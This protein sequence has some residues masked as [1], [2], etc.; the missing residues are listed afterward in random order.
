MPQDCR[1]IKRHRRHTG[2]VGAAL[3][4]AVMWHAASKQFTGGLLDLVV[5]APPSA[6]LGLVSTWSA[7]AFAPTRF[8]WRRG[9]IGVLAGGVVLSPLIAFLVAFAAAWDRA[10]FQ[11]VFN[12]GAWVAF[13]G[14]FGAAGSAW[15]V[16]W[17]REWRRSGRSGAVAPCRSQRRTRAMKTPVSGDIIEGTFHTEG[18]G[19]S[20]MPADGRWRVRRAA[21]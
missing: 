17:V 12:V 15:V 19:I 7:H 1:R 2:V 10:S 5:F 3:I 13:A 14:G 11:F 18:S 6:A 16:Q 20:H 4:A 21:P 9:L 8:T